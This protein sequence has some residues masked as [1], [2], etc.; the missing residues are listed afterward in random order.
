MHFRLTHLSSLYFLFFFL[1]NRT[2][3]SILNWYMYLSIVILLLINILFYFFKL[4]CLRMYL[5]FHICY[6]NMRIVLIFTIYFK[7]IFD[8][9]WCTYVC[10]NWHYSYFIVNLL[11]IFRDRVSQTFVILIQKIFKNSFQHIR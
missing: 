7:L 6:L 1:K 5:L 4:I 11:T 8:L 10:I 9:T 3:F 2:N